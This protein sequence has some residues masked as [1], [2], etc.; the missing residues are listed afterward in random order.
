MIFKDN[1]EGTSIGQLIHDL[2]KT[3]HTFFQQKLKPYN[4]G[5]GQIRTLFFI[6]HHEDLTSKEIAEYLKLDKS[7]VTSQMQI[8]ERNGYIQRVA[9]E[10]DGRKQNIKLT[11]KAKQVLGPVKEMLHLWTESLLEGF[12][13]DEIQSLSGYLKRMRENVGQ[14]ISR[15]NC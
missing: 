9:C 12:S 15:E 1:I 11:E 10:K 13:Q 5:H 2:S 4:L 6:A 7:S 3:S 14:Q 8:L